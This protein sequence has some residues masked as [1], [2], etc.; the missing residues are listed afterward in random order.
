MRQLPLSFLRWSQKLPLGPW[1][2]PKRGMGRTVRWMYV[3]MAAM[4]TGGGALLMVRCAKVILG[5]GG[6]VEHGGSCFGFV[7]DA[8]APVGAAVRELLGL[9]GRCSEGVARA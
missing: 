5:A 2:G 8:L 4:R 9:G 6:N 1:W 3:L 7:E